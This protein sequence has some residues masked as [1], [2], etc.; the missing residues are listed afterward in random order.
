MD[1]DGA[2]QQTDGQAEVF[3]PVIGLVAK[4]KSPSGSRDVFIP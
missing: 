2:P 3:P 4:V 1:S